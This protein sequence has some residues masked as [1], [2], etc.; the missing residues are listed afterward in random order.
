MMKR[1]R[2]RRNP[3]R[4]IKLPYVVNNT[5]STPQFWSFFDW[6]PRKMRDALNDEY[7]SQSTWRERYNYAICNYWQQYKAEHGL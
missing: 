3:P 4:K 7:I 6:L 1:R 5:L 2:D